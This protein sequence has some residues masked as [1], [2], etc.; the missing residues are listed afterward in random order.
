MTR[1]YIITFAFVV[2]RFATDYVPY[3]SWW[4]IS[5]QEMAVAMIWPVWVVPLLAYDLYLQYRER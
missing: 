5:P 1:S 2:F 4:G 3:E